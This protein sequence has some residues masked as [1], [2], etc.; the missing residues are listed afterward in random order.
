LEARLGLAAHCHISF[1]SL[2]LLPFAVHLVSRTTAMCQKF[3][4][5]L[6]LFSVA[7]ASPLQCTASWARAE[8]NP[9]HM[10]G[11]GEARVPEEIPE[12]GS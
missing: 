9:Q 12:D 5:Q 1:P 4:A 3:I 7:F 11:S 2:V 10:N 8:R 6:A